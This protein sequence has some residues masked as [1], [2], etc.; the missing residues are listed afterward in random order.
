MFRI[1]DTKKI[2]SSELP[3]RNL[4]ED[5]K[6]QVFLLLTKKLGYLKKLKTDVY[7]R[8][9]K[10]DIRRSLLVVRDYKIE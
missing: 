8:T 2:D 4:T 3:G 6:H 1:K 9:L 10:N 5:K 7:Q